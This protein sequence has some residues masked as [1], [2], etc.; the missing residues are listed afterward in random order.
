[1]IQCN[2]LGT[3]IISRVY[4]APILHDGRCS[5]QVASRIH[6]SERRYLN[7]ILIC[8]NLLRVK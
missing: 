3:G 7:A 2:Y 4:V 5:G 6:K 1:M 8:G